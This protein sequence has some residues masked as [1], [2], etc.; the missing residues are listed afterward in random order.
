MSMLYIWNP[1]L[2]EDKTRLEL[3]IT[4]G[5]SDQV[6][7]GS[8]EFVASLVK[9][10]GLSFLPQRWSIQ[11]YRCNFYSEYWQEEGWKS[12]WDFVW[13]LTAHFD[14]PVNPPDLK[15]P[16][17]ETDETDDYSPL[18]ESYKQPPYQCLVIAQYLSQKQVEAAAS[19][20][21]GDR[22]IEA[23]RRAVGAPAPVIDL[24]RLN[25]RQFQL[26]AVIGAGGEEFFLSDY[27]ARMV[28]MLAAGGAITH[29]ER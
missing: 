6:G 25:A 23:A 20:M 11:S 12:K 7:N 16:Y 29:A 13:R 28:A 14:R 26:R 1:C 21:V 24:L 27:P 18:V 5:D 15:A 17:L 19:K 9:G 8:K 4:R 3:I 10:M 2:N 22:E